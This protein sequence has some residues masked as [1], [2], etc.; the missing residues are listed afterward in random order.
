M[1]RA[2]PIRLFALFLLVPLPVAANSGGIT[3]VSGKQNVFC[4]S[5]H[6]GGSAPTVALELVEPAMVTPGAIVTFRFRVH[7]EGPEQVAAGLNIAAQAGTLGLVDNQGTRLA[8]GEIT[9]VAPK[10]NDAGGDAAWLFTWQA[11]T[12]PGTYKL[13]AAGNSVNLNELQTRDYAEKTTLD[14]AVNAPVPTATE[15]AIPSASATEAA[16][17]S[18][19]PTVPAPTETPTSLPTATATAFQ[20]VSCTGDCDAGGDVTVD[21]IIIGVN[22]ALGNRPLDECGRFDRNQD[23]EVTVDEIVDAIQRALNGC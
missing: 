15:T 6:F 16:T 5:C 4:T 8:A 11:P 19:T 14:V 12:A 17:P 7:S 2:L 3:G 20:P 9:H 22:I 18:Q 13:Y 10:D 1:L 21:E 23:G